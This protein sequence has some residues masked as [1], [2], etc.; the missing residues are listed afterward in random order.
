MLNQDGEIV[1]PRHLKTHPDAWLKVMAPY[2]A[3]LVIAGEGVFT[4][5]LAGRPLR[6]GGHALRAE[7]CALHAG[8]SRWQGHTRPH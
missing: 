4:W 6:S 5:D 1:T 3:D 8:H 2:R 7:P